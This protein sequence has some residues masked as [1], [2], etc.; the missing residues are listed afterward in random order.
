MDIIDIFKPFFDLINFLRIGFTIFFFVVGFTA[1]FRSRDF[2]KAIITAIFLF[3]V[4]TVF[5]TFL[6]NIQGTEAQVLDK[7]YT[8]L[9]LIGGFVLGKILEWIAKR[10]LM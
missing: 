5:S 7:Y 10:L 9:A 4:T 1:A 2:L 3:L 6:Q 8:L